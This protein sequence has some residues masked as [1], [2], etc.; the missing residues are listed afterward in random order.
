MSNKVNS[1]SI[2]CSTVIATLQRI[3][4]NKTVSNSISYPISARGLEIC[5]RADVICNIR[6]WCCCGGC[7]SGIRCTVEICWSAGILTDNIVVTFRPRTWVSKHPIFSTLN[8]DQ[9]ICLLLCVRL[10]LNLHAGFAGVLHNIVQRH[11]LVVPN[12]VVVGAVGVGS[13]GDVVAEGE[14]AL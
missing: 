1:G 14:D 9:A 5:A 12:K 8:P 13:V 2:Q 7:C 6:L 3:W 11:N 4:L 10:I